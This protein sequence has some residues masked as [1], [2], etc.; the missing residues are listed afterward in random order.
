M[1]MTKADSCSIRNFYKFSKIS[2][3]NLLAKYSLLKILWGINEFILKCH[4]WANSVLSYFLINTY[5]YMSVGV[6]LS[7]IS[8]AHHHSLNGYDKSTEVAFRG[9]HTF[10]SLQTVYPAE[11]TMVPPAGT[12]HQRP[13][14]CIWALPFLWCTHVTWS[15]EQPMTFPNSLYKGAWKC[16]DIC[17]C[18]RVFI[19]CAAVI[20]PEGIVHSLPVNY[21]SFINQ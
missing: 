17:Q 10:S 4:I 20:D 2:D 14:V 11:D 13:C 21:A 16:V 5:F 8:L 3:G 19:C 7:W 12:Q 6:I 18:L 15:R 1:P 9:A